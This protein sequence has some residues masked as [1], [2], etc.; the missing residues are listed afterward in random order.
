MERA[1]ALIGACF[2]D[3]RQRGQFGHFTIK[4][5]VSDEE[6][7]AGNQKAEGRKLNSGRWFLDS[8]RSAL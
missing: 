1:R 6:A 3:V 5:A 4:F 8:F 7:V 2:A